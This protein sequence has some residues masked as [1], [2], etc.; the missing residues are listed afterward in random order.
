MGSA[1]CKSNNQSAG[2]RIEKGKIATPQTQIEKKT[3]V[4]VSDAVSTNS[5]KVDDETRAEQVVELT[6]D[7]TINQTAE[8]AE[9]KPA[10]AQI[11]IT[12]VQMDEAIKTNLLQN[13][14]GQHTNATSNLLKGHVAE[15]YNKAETKRIASVAQQ[16]AVEQPVADVVSPPQGSP[17]L[18]VTESVVASTV[19]S[20]V[21]ASTS[22]AE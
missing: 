3:T 15:S 14:V 5:S 7:P 20:Q 8:A 4:V 2:P 16:Q 10:I 21:P 19:E 17:P 18:P 11:K 12:R 22:T 6:W 13:F 9:N 1:C